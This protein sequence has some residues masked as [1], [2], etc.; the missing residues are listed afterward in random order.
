MHMINL[1]SCLYVV[2]ISFGA[3]SCCISLYEYEYSC[4]YILF[5]DF[6]KFIHRFCG[7]IRQLPIL[8]ISILI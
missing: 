4:E 1:Y 2:C 3:I 5:F 7:L 8:F 6:T